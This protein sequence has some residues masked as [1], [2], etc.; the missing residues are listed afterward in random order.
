VLAYSTIS[1][2]GYMFMAAGAGA[3][4]AAVFHLA[5]HAFFKALLFLAAGSVIHGMG[6]EQD[7]FKMGGLKKEMP[8]TF[9]LMASGWLAISGFP[10][11]SGFYS[12]D[13]ILEHVFER[14]GP[15]LWG[16]GVL[17]AALTAFYTTRLIILAFL[18]AKRGE[19]H[20]HES[21]AVMTIPMGVLAFL[22]LAGGFLLK[23]RLITFLGGPGAAPEAPN[24]EASRLMLISVTAGLAGIAAAFPLT[25]PKAANFLKNT[26]APV[27]ALV[28]NKF[29][30]DEIYGLLLIR[31]LR[32]FS[33]RVLFALVDAG[34]I[35][36]VM[37]N[38]TARVSYSA[39]RRL[40]RLQG[41]RLDRYALIFALGVA[42]M[43]FWIL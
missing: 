38:G 7:L 25:L 36:G 22:A 1:Q 11:F 10:G 5:T 34:L 16:A 43:L 30:V 27:H 15:L 9:A 23:S 37:V 31:P 35:D 14:G 32:Y 17:T 13:L 19:K 18:R 8:V 24:P 39:G 2:L 21:P 4:S 40:A 26:M 3:Y 33:N 28:Y 42:A 29:Y 12:K 20:A 41:G 6:G